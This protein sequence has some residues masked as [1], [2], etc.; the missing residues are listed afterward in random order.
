M[1]RRVDIIIGGHGWLLLGVVASLKVNER[2]QWI[3]TNYKKFFFRVLIK[4]SLDAEEVESTTNGNNGIGT[5]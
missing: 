4:R 3:K 5:V 2:M 1:C